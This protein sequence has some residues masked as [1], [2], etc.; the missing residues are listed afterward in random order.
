[1][2]KKVVSDVETAAVAPVTPVVEKRAESS[3]VLVMV[4]I[5]FKANMIT[6]HNI[7]EILD[8][9]SKP[10]PEDL[11]GWLTKESKK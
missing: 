9:I 11:A 7:A 6:R 10:F 8:I 4:Y 3:V 1:M 5:L 2:S